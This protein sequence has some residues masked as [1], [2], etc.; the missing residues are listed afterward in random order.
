MS[1]FTLS[2]GGRFALFVATLA[3][4]QQLPPV[5]HGNYTIVSDDHRRILQTV[6]RGACAP[7]MLHA[8]LP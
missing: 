3:L 1:V 2:S 8:P 6:T 5:L 4:A 7:S